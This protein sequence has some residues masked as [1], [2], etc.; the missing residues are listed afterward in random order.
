[1]EKF[2]RLLNDVKIPFEEGDWQTIDRD[3]E[4]EDNEKK[5]TRH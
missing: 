1:L 4:R 5:T 2:K 3:R